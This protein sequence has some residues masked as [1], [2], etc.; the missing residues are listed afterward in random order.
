MQ[1]TVTG[2]YFLILIQLSLLL[3]KF[4]TFRRFKPRF[5]AEVL[6]KDEVTQCSRDGQED[7]VCMYVC[8]KIYIRRAL[9]KVTDA[10]RSQTK[11]YS[12][13]V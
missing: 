5:Q 11:M 2:K 6:T 10:L 13:P 9:N 7:S 1:A 8:P 4:E 3:P 12:M